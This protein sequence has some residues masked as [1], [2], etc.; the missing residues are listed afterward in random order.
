MR[1]SDTGVVEIVAT[2]SDAYAMD[3]F[4]VRMEGGHGAAIGDFEAAWNC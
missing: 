2:Y 4:F 1:G 3:L